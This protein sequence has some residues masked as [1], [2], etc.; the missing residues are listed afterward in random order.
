VDDIMVSFKGRSSLKQY[1]Q[2]KPNPWGF[3]LWGRA[4]ASGVLYDFDDY[5][6]KTGR[7]RE[8]YIGVG[9][10]TVLQ[11]SSIGAQLI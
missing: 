9:G 10:D 3:K 7:Q 6:G 2:G 11:M 4:G 5:Q 8:D 1:I